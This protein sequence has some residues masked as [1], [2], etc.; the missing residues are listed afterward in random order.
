MQVTAP[1]VTVL[2]AADLRVI[3]TRP[4]AQADEWVTQ[5]RS[6]GIDAVALP[7]IHIAPADDCTPQLDAAW[8]RLARPTLPTSLNPLTPLTPL[9]PPLAPLNRLTPLSPLTPLDRPPPPLPT[10]TSF[11]PPLDR[12]AGQLPSQLSLVMFVSPNA[13][14]HFFARRPPGAVWPA[15]LFAGSPGPGTT[16]ALRRLGVP[17]PQ[18]LEPAADAPQ[19]DSQALWTELAPLD[20]QGREALIV[21]GDGGRD[22]L[23][24]MLRSRGAE[25]GFVT[26]YRRTAPQLD[27]TQRLLL[28]SAR[29]RPAVFLWFFSSSEAIDHLAALTGA[30]A[31][32][33]SGDGGPA[34]HHSR[35]IATHPRIVARARE[36]GFGSVVAARPSLPAVVACIQS[37]G[38]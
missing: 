22:W 7:L 10:L 25:V 34:W 29:V 37:I 20:W 15:A 30:D 18:I 12:P 9:D 21:R 14:L 11:P 19:F 28:Q 33:H 1:Q 3:V 26:A 32:R 36:L 6:Q 17:P 4:A 16:Q 8:R 31:A 38:T 24:G 13:V 2:Q 27:A 35:A 23:A 5:L